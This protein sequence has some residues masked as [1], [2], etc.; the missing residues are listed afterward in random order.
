MDEIA[1]DLTQNDS[2]PKKI[3]KKKVVIAIL[4]LLLVIFLILISFTKILKNPSDVSLVETGK[5]EEEESVEGY[6]IRSE[7]V[8][9]GNNYK[10]GIVQ[11]KA[12]GEKV[13]KNSPVFRYYTKGEDEL[14]EK[15]EDLDIKI[16][17]AMSNQTDIFS[18]D[19]K[20]L[21]TQIEEKIDD[22]YTMKDIQKI[23]E[24]KKD[25][26]S[27]IT[28]R[29]KIAGELS[30]AGSYIK[31][32][33]EERKNYE[34]ELNNGAEYINATDSG[35]VS[36]RVDGLEEIL[37]PEKFSSL[38]VS[39]LENLNIKTGQIIGTSNEAGKII[40]NYECYIAC[41]MDS[42]RA[43]NSKVGDE[44]ELMIDDQIIDAKI[45]YVTDE[46][47]KRIIVFKIEKDVEEL[48]NYRKISLDV[49]WW[50]KSGWKVPVSVLYT[51]ETPIANNS[52]TKEENKKVYYVYRNRGGYL[53]KI[54]VKVLKDN[55]IYAIIDNYKDS[56]L[57]ELGYTSEQLK[58]RVTL[59]LYD[60]VEV[61]SE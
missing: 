32:L 7:K 34:N 1:D 22:I 39:M 4:S 8:I 42:E 49:I 11:I 58:N 12:E 44:L 43:K 45:Q 21:E 51:E 19:M 30:P 13:A 56:E 47:D 61:K 27:D 41:I 59:K 52:D 18:S 48:V 9:K 2:E 33:I 37:T 35:L 31:Q 54:Y 23:N 26:N 20:V 29:A 10:N 40:N 6:I 55:G 36:Y 17:E 38:S 14:I 24:Y 46:N 16:Q 15:I 53:D 57:K 28:K 3:K 5:I 25:I 50:S 60:E